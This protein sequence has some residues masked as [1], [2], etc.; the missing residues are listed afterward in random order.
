MDIINSICQ[1]ADNLET[2]ANLAIIFFSARFLYNRMWV[3]ITLS[4]GSFKVQR[5]EINASNLTNLV[6]QYF[7]E[8]DRMP[9]EVREE[10][11]SITNPAVKQVSKIK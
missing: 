9:S 11:I 7:Y 5:K 2:L 6:S 4:V 3:T 8:G 1:F 10:I